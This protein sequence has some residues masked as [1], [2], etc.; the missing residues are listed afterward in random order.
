MPADIG[1]ET[2]W[3]QVSRTRRDRPLP[4]EPTTTTSGS[5][6]SSRSGNST[7]ASMSRPTTKY[8]ARRKSSSVRT[9]FVAWA[10][11]TRAAAPAEVF[12]AAAVMPTDRRS[13]STTP[14]PPKAATERTIAPRLRGSVMPSSATTS[15]TPG[16][17]GSCRSAGSRYR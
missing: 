13:G 8:P 2:I 9:R 6:A 14:C 1:I 11:G 7:S 15:G 4:S 16:L 17:S 12:Q 3:S 10:T 5:V